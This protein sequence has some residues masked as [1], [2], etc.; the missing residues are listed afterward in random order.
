MFWFLTEHEKV[1]FLPATKMTVS[2][3]VQYSSKYYAE[4]RSCVVFSSQNMNVGFIALKKSSTQHQNIIYTW[5]NER[6]LNIHKWHEDESAVTRW[7]ETP[8]HPMLVHVCVRSC[9]CVCMRTC[10]RWHNCPF[11]TDFTWLHLR[12]VF[13]V[14]SNFILCLRVCYYT[15]PNV[16][17]SIWE[18]APRNCWVKQP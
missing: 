7:W 18:P 1:F 3:H 13:S 11:K 12:R 9:L 5:R 4:I 2:T 15:P 6:I 14:F 10:M 8:S 16:K 17:P